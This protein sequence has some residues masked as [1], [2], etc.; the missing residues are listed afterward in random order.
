[1]QKF[2]LF[3]EKCES[4]IGLNDRH[5]C[6]GCTG[7]MFIIQQSH[8][9]NPKQ[10]TL[11][12]FRCLTMKG[13]WFMRNLEQ[14]GKPKIHSQGEP[15][16]FFGD[17]DTSN[18]DKMLVAYFWGEKVHDLNL[19]QSGRRKERL[20]KTIQCWCVW[21][22]VGRGFCGTWFLRFCCRRSWKR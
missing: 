8:F 21:S 3:E 17:S 10:V 16:K 5:I 2:Y 7:K 19:L 11:L 6:I 1:M 15:L 13:R 4:F 14:S 22:G 20:R 9:M 18:Q 12:W